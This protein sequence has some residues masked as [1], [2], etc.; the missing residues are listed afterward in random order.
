MQ[1][2]ARC[3]GRD[4]IEEEGLRMEQRVSARDQSCLILA[5]SGWAIDICQCRPT[6][7]FSSVLQRD[8]PTLNV[9]PASMY[10]PLPSPMGFMRF[11]CLELRPAI[12][13]ARH[14][15]HPREVLCCARAETRE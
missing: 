14:R 2:L 1:H 4:P 13:R 15:Q 12:S 8:I 6:A 11:R 9:L 7:L 3:C 5:T 10:A